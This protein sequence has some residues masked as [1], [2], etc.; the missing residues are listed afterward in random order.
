[1]SIIKDALVL[2]NSNYN[3]LKKEE[4]DNKPEIIKNDVLAMLTR[5]NDVTS[6]MCLQC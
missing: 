1:M 6:M 3:T 2:K 4:V 5:D